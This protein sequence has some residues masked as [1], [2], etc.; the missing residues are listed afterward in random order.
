MKLQQL[1]ILPVAIIRRKEEFSH[2]TQ[3]GIRSKTIEGYFI[4][5]VMVSNE[6]KIREKK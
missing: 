1:E 6:I 4:I 3:L 5:I 2:I